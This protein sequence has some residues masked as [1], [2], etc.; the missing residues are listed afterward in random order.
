MPVGNPSVI[1]REIDGNLHEPV[2]DL[3]IEVPE[4]HVG[5]VTQLLGERRAQMK[6]MKI[7]GM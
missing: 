2:E 4:E 3:T 1:L 5:A 7:Y 6:E